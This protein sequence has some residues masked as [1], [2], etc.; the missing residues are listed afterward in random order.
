MTGPLVRDAALDELD[1]RTLYAI[2]ALR[3]EVFV[4]EQACPYLDPDGRDLEPAARH[5]WI[6]E[7]GQVLA[8]LR[9]LQE[10]DG[11]A[12]IGRVCTARAGRGRGLGGHLMEAALAHAGERDSVLQAQAHLR[13][14][15]E[16]LGYVATSEEYLE[17]G[18][19]HVDM[20]RPGETYS[21]G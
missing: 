16:G 8:Y 10:P 19:P 14:W 21:P 11:T 6:E 12:R 20:R 9:V 4:V 13:D 7:D 1:A 18:I 2:L 3:A 17:D 5:L 15:Y